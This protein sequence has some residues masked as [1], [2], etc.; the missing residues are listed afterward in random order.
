MFLNAKRDQSGDKN[1][2]TFSFKMSKRPEKPLYIP[3]SRRS[4][5][6]TNPS[7]ESPPKVTIET[8][9]RIIHAWEIQEKQEKQE[10]K[11]STKEKIIHAWELPQ[12]NPS[13]KS[14]DHTIKLDK[15][16]PY[17]G[18]QKRKDQQDGN[19]KMNNTNSHQ[20]LQQQKQSQIQPMINQKHTPPSIQIIKQEKKPKLVPV[21]EIL[22]NQG[23]WADESEEFDYSIIPE[24]K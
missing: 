18:K 4:I 6:N 1:H 2:G 20:Q 12:E 7:N 13:I 15:K 17:R 3:P 16:Q 14:I 10:P 19:P 11:V 9:E 24:W 8:K 21:Q 23:N 5:I 22:K